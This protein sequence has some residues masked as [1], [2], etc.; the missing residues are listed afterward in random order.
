MTHSGSSRYSIPIGQAL[1]DGDSTI[2]YAMGKDKITPTYIYFEK[3]LV[4]VQLGEVIHAA[5]TRQNREDK[6]YING[7]YK[8]EDHYWTFR[9]NSTSPAQMIKTSFTEG[10][11]TFN[12]SSRVSI[13]QIH[14]YK[15]VKDLYGRI[16]TYHHPLYFSPDGKIACNG[17][18]IKATEDIEISNIYGRLFDLESNSE[19]EISGEITIPE[20]LN[21]D[22]LA[23][24]ISNGKDLGMLLSLHSKDNSSKVQLA[25][26]EL[27]YD[28]AEAELVLVPMEDAARISGFYAK[29]ISDETFITTLL[30][31]PDKDTKKSGIL[32]LQYT[33]GEKLRGTISQDPKWWHGI[34]PVEIV[35]LSSELSL[36]MYNRITNLEKNK[37]YTTLYT[38]EHATGNIR[39]FSTIDLGDNEYAKPYIVLSGSRPYVFFGAYHSALSEAKAKGPNEIKCLYAD[40]NNQL[41]E[42]SVPGTRGLRMIANH[43]AHKGNTVL[44]KVQAVSGKIPGNGKNRKEGYLKLRIE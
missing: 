8:Q 37:G 9:D 14:K 33:Q 22:V 41:R 3:A 44:L 21:A 25:V 38:Y 40:D 23:A 29:Y 7:F 1:W 5:Y 24:A 11:L 13:A 27:K 32:S 12:D 17:L 42:Y 30:Y 2:Y 36:I 31:R 10:Q 6:N 16:K 39:Y 19:T 20:G 26:C 28:A 15:L 34:I 35:S 4:K 43:S 18:E